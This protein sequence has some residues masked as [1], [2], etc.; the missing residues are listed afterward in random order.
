MLVP[1]GYCCVIQRLLKFSVDV[2]E[3]G[4]LGSLLLVFR[5][6]HKFAVGKGHRGYMCEVFNG[7]FKLPDL[8]PIGECISFRTMSCDFRQ[9][10]AMVGANG[11]ANARDFETPV[12]SYEDKK[13]PYKLI[14][15]FCGE[16]WGTTLT[17][18]P[19]DVV[20]KLFWSFI[21]FL[22]PFSTFNFQAW[23]GNYAPYR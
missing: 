14:Q 1:P 7:H 12:A 21:H 22:A 23:H 17:H 19:F 9:P 10:H 4:L 2:E 15:K 3:E 20:V 6:L 16:L 18:S 13:G 5:I 8:G 11:L